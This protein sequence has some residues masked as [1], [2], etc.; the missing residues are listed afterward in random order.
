[1]N[2]FTLACL[3]NCPLPSNMALCVCVVCMDV[4]AYDLSFTFIFY[5]LFLE[6]VIEFV[7]KYFATST[8]I[9]FI[10]GDERL[11]ILLTSIC[12]LPWKIVLWCPSLSP[13]A[14]DVFSGIVPTLLLY[15]FYIF[16]LSLMYCD[17]FPAFTHLLW[18]PGSSDGKAS[19][20][21]AGELGSIPGS[22]RSPGEGNGNPLQYSCLENPLDQGAW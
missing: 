8:Y 6:T 17:L 22:G 12:H 20:Y 9:I 18:F 2:L 11:L 21:K 4:S 19:A 1:M 5:T 14:K 15:F 10:C 3:R 13:E 7:K 16:Q